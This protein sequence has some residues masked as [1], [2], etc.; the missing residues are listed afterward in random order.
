[1][2]IDQWNFEMLE[3]NV[4][5]KGHGYSIGNIKGREGGQ[6]EICFM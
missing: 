3:Y 2:M 4:L 1:M 6:R 5:V